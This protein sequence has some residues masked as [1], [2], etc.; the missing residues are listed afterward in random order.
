MARALVKTILAPQIAYL[1]DVK[2]S[3]T[4][5]GTG[6]ISYLAR[7]LN[8]LVDSTGII[9]NP[10]SF[11][12]TGGANTQF[13]LAA[14]TYRISGYAPIWNTSNASINTVYSRVRL[15]NITNSSITILGAAAN[16]TGAIASSTVNVSNCFIEGEFT[17]TSNTTFELQQKVSN[18]TTT[19][20]GSAATWGENEIYTQITITKIK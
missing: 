13:Q 5:A 19:A 1:S 4:S 9:K 12:G 6:S 17:I 18:T 20:L 10:S 11:T 16:P 14:G 3:G 7:T 2:T 15:Y 8:T